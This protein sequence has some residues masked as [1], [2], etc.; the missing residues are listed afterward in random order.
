MSC[1][2]AT[3]SH[4]QRQRDTSNTGPLI[5]VE[6]NQDLK[7]VRRALP[8]CQVILRCLLGHSGRLKHRRTL[9]CLHLLQVFVLHSANKSKST[10]TLQALQR[11]AAQHERV[12]VFLDNDT[13]GRQGR[14]VLDQALPACWHAFLPLT[15]EDVDRSV[16]MTGALVLPP[17]LQFSRTPPSYPNT[18]TGRLSS[19]Q[20]VATAALEFLPTYIGENVVQQCNWQMQ[21]VEAPSAGGN[22]LLNQIVP[23]SITSV[24]SAAAILWA[25]PSCPDTGNC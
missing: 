21:H 8:A 1:R 11:Q 23:T 3:V 22:A 25:C 20:S 16:D 10:A 4:G 14:K 12:V 7:A 6:G 9:L 24:P 19:V 15:I 2:S 5:V 17:L 13:A 18:D